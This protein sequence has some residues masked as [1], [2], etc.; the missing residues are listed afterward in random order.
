MWFFL[1]SVIIFGFILRIVD[2][3]FLV[4]KGKIEFETL[5]NPMWCI[6]ITMLTVGY[7]D[8]YPLTTMGK[9]CCFFMSLYGLFISSL[10]IVCL[11][12]L[13]ELS[14]DQFNVFVKVIHSRTA[15]KFIENTY[16]FHKAKLKQNNLNEAKYN[17]YSMVESYQEFRGM[18]NES[19]SVFRSNGLLYYNMKLI[20]ELKKIDRRMD[21]LESDIEMAKNILKPKVS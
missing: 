2:R 7:G 16:L 6:L 1:A 17:Y 15:M 18:R 9:I 19:K 3:P 8:F 12:G 4:Q 13:L 11:H 20:E 5:L 10:I 14:N 21:S